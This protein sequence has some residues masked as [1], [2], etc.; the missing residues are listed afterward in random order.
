[1]NEGAPEEMIGITRRRFLG[2]VTSISA[3]LSLPGGTWDAVRAEPVRPDNSEIVV[4]VQ[5]GAENGWSPKTSPLM[6]R[7]SSQVDAKMPHPEYPRPQL[8]RKDWLNLNGIWEYQPGTSADEPPPFG[9]QLSSA[10]LVPYPVESALSGV[11]EHH[12]R[13]WYRRMLKIPAGWRGRQVLLHFGAVDWESEVFVNG[14]SAG[15]H[16]GGYDPF[17][18]DI[19]PLISGKDDELMVR[20]FDPTQKG[21]QPRGKQNTEPRGITYTPTTGIWQTVWLEPVN[22]TYIEDLSMIPDIDAGKLRL[23][24]NSS[25]AQPGATVDVLVKG[26]D[27]VVAKMSVPANTDAAISVPNPKLWSPDTPFLYTL[28]M[29]LKQDGRTLD[30]AVS[31]FGM[32]KLSVGDADGQKKLLLNNQF[33]FEIGPL[34]QGFWPDGIYTAPTDAALKDDI[35]QMKAMGFNMVRKHIKVEPARWYYWADTLGILVWQDM[36]SCNSYPGRAFV[37]PQEDKTAFE[38]E[39]RHMVETHRNVPSI[40]LWTVFNEGQGQF[41][42]GRMVDIVQSLDPSRPINEASGGEITGA[43]EINDIHSYPEPAVRA[44]NGRQALACGEFGG[45]GYLVA[46]HSWQGEGHG[47]A[48]C[49]NANDLLYLYAEFFADV[50]RLRDEKSLSAVVYTELT[51]VMTEI[52]GLLTYDRVLKLPAE[53]IKQINSFQFKTPEYKILVLTSETTA[54]E[55]RYVTKKPDDAWSAKDYDDAQWQTGPAPFGDQGHV[56]TSWTTPDLWLRRH[57]NPGTISPE[58]L[59][60]LVM[61]QFNRGRVEIFINGVQ[62]FAQ[63]G[64]NRSLEGGYEH[65]PL[66]TPVRNAIIPGGDNLIAVHCFTQPAGGPLYFD[67]GLALRMA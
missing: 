22:A 21:G 48:E 29:A 15:V 37:P 47:Y 61:K 8:M 66:S 25:K 54:Q 9:K 28:D 56:G 32:R 27:T 63:Q 40:V 42:T 31:Y 7:W 65:R 34:D 2:Q 4:A 59:Q 41:D 55:W 67:A 44:A 16:L 12:D 50:K 39:L 64:N 10:I 38:R 35:V 17:T 36:P 30:I 46:D 57:F 60:N 53:Q 58:E 1:M 23:K 20:V 62:T 45:I 52:N 5:N 3:V 26:G 11:M 14:K 18:Y 51:D 13:L 33:V 24:V 19:T 43:G 6:T 49:A